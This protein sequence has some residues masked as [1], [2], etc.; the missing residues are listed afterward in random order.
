MVIFF[1]LIIL[2]T[3]LCILLLGNSSISQGVTEG[4][5]AVSSVL[6]EVE[7]VRNEAMGMAEEVVL[8]RYEDMLEDIYINR[9]K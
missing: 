9:L 7:R 8:G 3:F 2:V 5:V 1:L 4:Y 6:G